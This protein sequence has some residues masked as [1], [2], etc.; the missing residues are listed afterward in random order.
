LIFQE[1]PTSIADAFL[2]RVLATPTRTAFTYREPARWREVSWSE[3]YQRVKAISGGLHALGLK[4]GDCVAI[5]SQT[6]LE[7]ALCDYSGQV[8][9]CVTVPIY[10]SNL[11]DEVAFALSNSQAKCVIVEN[12]EQL[13]KV[14]QIASE[15]SDL[16]FI[17]VMDGSIDEEA[18]AGRRA[19]GLQ[20][21]EK[22][23]P[24]SQEQLSTIAASMKPSDLMTIIYTSG[25]TG[26]PKGACL[27]QSCF[28]SVET[29]I[30]RMDLSSDERAL[31]FLPFAHVLG[32]VELYLP[33]FHGTHL[34]FAQNLNT[35]A[36]DMIIAKP[37]VLLSVPRIYEKVY[38]KILASVEAGPVSKKAIFHWALQVGLRVSELNEQKKSLPL[39]LFAQYR[40]AKRLVFDKILARF[41]GQVKF[42]ISGGAP[43]SKDIARFLDACGIHV[44]E[45]YGLTETTGPLTV[46][47]PDA[48]RFGTVGL[49]LCPDVEIKIAED[50]E[51]LARGS[52]VFTGYYRN[53][54]ES[55]EALTKDG[56][57]RTGDIGELRD[58]YLAIT[59]RKKD[60]IATSAGKKI[61]PQMIE[62]LLKLEPLV[63]QALIVGDR[64][65]YIA[66]LVTLDR[67]KVEEYARSRGISVT[68]YDDLVNDLTIAKVVDDGVAH[69]NAKLPSYAT[70]KKYRVLPSDFSIENGE[71]TPSLKVKRK[72][73]TEKYSHEIK[74]LYNS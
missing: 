74:S 27:P 31:T 66:A 41:G 71:L 43:L 26:V 50:G 60:L 47:R 44:Y 11:P 30:K 6:R 19:L 70:I 7:W 9:G 59:D 45:G 37:T 2:K 39:S 33:I 3:V 68:S 46:N 72:V 15:L 42:A 62:N 5:L 52:C 10:P 16:K 13:D 23:T 49:P 32:R 54:K 58:G 56:F 51:I 48:Y 67:Q 12:R 38:T 36:D 57:F 40:I 18:V 35:I 69:V 8:L 65:K 14:K 4:K 17:V 20:I 55:E 1:M 53:E 25:T 34:W 29:A 21:L 61:A 64:Q 63:S 73:C 28:L 24:L 22:S